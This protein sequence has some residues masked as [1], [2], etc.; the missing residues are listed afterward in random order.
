M[1]KILLIEDN[2]EMRENTSEILGLDNYA[3]IS[4]E[5]GKVGVELAKK[6]KPDLIICDI[7]MP[8]LDGYGVSIFWVKILKLPEFL[9]YSLLPKLKKAICEK[10]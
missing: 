9:L 2:R 6:E 7:M 10:E 8:D 1:K 3:V 5:N 4:A